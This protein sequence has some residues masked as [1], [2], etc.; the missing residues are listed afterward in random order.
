MGNYC[1]F[2][3][4][5]AFPQGKMKAFTMSYDDGV[6]Q[7]ERLIGLMNKN[8]V[9]GTFNLN[10]GLYTPEGFKFP[11]GHIHRRLTE[12]KATEVYSN[13]GHEVAVHG[14]SHPFFDKIPQ[15]NRIFEVIEDRKNLEIQFKTIVRGM[16]YPYSYPQ[17]LRPVLEQCK[18]AYARTTFSTGTFDIPSDWLVLK[19]TCHHDDERLF[20]LC[21]KFVNESPFDPYRVPDPWLFYLWGHS[22]EFEDHNNWD[23]IEKFLEKI[24]N[25][26]DIWYATNIEIYDYIEAFRRLEYS[27][28]C[29]LVKNPS[30]IDVW[31]KDARGETYCIKAGETLDLA[32]KL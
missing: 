12:K 14:L 30:G 20:D 8:G 2:R 15:E 22:Y 31:I 19:P 16:A 18:I 9:K 11:E 17:S 27:V 29:Y 6:E 21:D 25:K 32:K 1:F 24:G 7:D 23:R 10:S 3:L 26:D 4:N 5:M 13:S 28:F